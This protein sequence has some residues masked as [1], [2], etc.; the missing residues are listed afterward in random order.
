MSKVMISI[1]VQP[2]GCPAKRSSVKNI[3]QGEWKNRIF[4]EIH[5]LASQGVFFFYGGF[6]GMDGVCMEL[7]DRIHMF[8][9]PV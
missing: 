4:K 9:S 7:L 5:K 1:V 2:A 3:S 6:G 8:T